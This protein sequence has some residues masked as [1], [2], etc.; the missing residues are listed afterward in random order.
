MTTDAS[1]QPIRWAVLGT[2]AIARSF[3]EDLRLLPDAVLIAACSRDAGRGR[4]FLDAY[5]APGRGKVYTSVEDLARD[6]DI[7]VVYVA[8]PHSRH[9]VDCITCLEAGRAV[10]CEKPFAVDVDEARAIVEVARRTGKFCMEAMWMRFHP[11][12][13]KVGELIHS[14]RLG[15][16]RYL[17]ADFGYPTPYDPEGR[18]FNPALGGGALL[19]RGVYPLSLA[20]MLLGNPS[21]IYGRAA[22]APSGVDEQ[23]T[24]LL[25]YPSGAQATLTSSLRS[26]LRNEALIVGT[27]GTIRIHE[28]FFAP[29]RVSLTPHQELVGS[30]PHKE[31]SRPGGWKSKLKRSPLARRVVNGIAK[32]MLRVLK[33]ESTVFTEYVPGGGYQFEAAEVMRRLRAGETESPI[34]SLD[35]TIAVME[36]VSALRRSWATK[37]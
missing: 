34:M 22:L 19:D 31:D 37:I 27:A 25:T 13:A 11:L 20:Q 6:G 3:V 16:V 29:T 10:L 7:D 36:T 23:E 21:D 8:T 4:A 30:T 18:F 9:K 26:R 17:T 33:N 14:G 12:I 28:P 15:R 2:G 1:T 24:S 32:P 5:A 35:D